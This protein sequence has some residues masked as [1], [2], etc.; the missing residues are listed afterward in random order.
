[1]KQA[2]NV[3]KHRKKELQA[4]G[5]CRQPGREEENTR[6]EGKWKKGGGRRKRANKREEGGK[7]EGNRGKKGKKEEKEGGKIKIDKGIK[8]ERKEAGG[9][10]EKSTCK[11]KGE[12]AR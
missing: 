11:S 8:E 7:V 3:R 9:G 10:E 12:G 1:M 4:Y 5:H 2:K 6:N